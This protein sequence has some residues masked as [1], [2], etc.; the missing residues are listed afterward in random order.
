MQGLISQP[1]DHYLSRNQ[2]SDAPP[3]DHPG[4]P[5]SLMF[6]NS[7]GSPV[8]NPSLLPALTGTFWAVDFLVLDKGRQPA[9]GPPAGPAPV[10]PLPAVKPVVFVQCVASAESLA[11]LR[12]GKGLLLGVGLPVQREVGLPAEGFATFPALERPLA[13]VQPL[14][15]EEQAVVLEGLL[16][17]GALVELVPRGS[18]VCCAEQGILT[19][20]VFSGALPGVQ[21]VVLEERGPTDEALPALQ[22]RVRPL[23][24]VDAAVLVEGEPAA[25]GLP[26]LATLVGL[27]P[28]VELLVLPEPGAAAKGLPALATLVGLL[29]RVDSVVCRQLSALPE[30]LAAVAALVGLLLRVDQLVSQQDGALLEGLAALGAL[31]GL[32]PRVDDLVSEQQRVVLEGLAAGTPV[33]PTPNSV[34]RAR[35]S[36][37]LLRGLGGCAKVP[38]RTACLGVE[39]SFI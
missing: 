31:V 32:G 37:F 6:I 12:A 33:H 38:T 20:A 1:R 9:A 14:V 22:A 23:P 24:A 28:R 18:L 29:P 8:G 35:P 19:A 13:R 11:T 26:A 16:A 17:H 34:H 5:G 4:T 15:Q 36:L 21:S 7:T 10:R 30:G 25:E 2:K 27:L 3:T 39:G